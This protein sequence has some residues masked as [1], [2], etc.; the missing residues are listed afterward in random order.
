M[1]SSGVHEIWI[2]IGVEINENRVEEERKRRLLK[3]LL[4]IRG[5]G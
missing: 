5:G 2:Q 3:L 1:N 4:L